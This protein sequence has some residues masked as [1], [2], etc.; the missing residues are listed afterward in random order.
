MNKLIDELATLSLAQYDAETRFR[1]LA[2]TGSAR[3]E[4]E[5]LDKLY[6]A[7]RCG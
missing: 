6:K 2:T 4:V 7:F 5:L 3:K 1:A